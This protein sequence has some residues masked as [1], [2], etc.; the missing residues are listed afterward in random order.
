MLF[1]LYKQENKIQEFCKITKKTL[2]KLGF[3]D[4]VVTR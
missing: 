2:L 3:E 1:L 4:V